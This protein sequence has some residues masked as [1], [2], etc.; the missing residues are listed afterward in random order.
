[1]T[2]PRPPRLPRYYGLLAWIILPPLIV[3]TIALDLWQRRRGQSA[4][5]MR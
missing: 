1:M 4:R 3:V 5:R 2:T